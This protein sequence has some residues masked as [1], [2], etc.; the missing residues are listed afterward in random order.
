MRSSII[1]KRNIQRSTNCK[2]KV[3]KSAPC[4]YIKLC[5]RIAVINV[6]IY[7]SNHFI[8]DD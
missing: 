8:E 6:I 4:Y 1:S 3:V 7:L 5:F 2:R